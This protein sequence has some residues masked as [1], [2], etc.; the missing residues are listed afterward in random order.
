MILENVLPFFED[1]LVSLTRNA[2]VYTGEYTNIAF[3]EN[4]QH[5]CRQI[6]E[7]KH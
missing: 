6:A 3:Q 2:A 1:K 5:F 7:I 4:R